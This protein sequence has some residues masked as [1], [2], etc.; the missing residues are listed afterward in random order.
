[1]KHIWSRSDFIQ[2][3]V[4]CP[5]CGRFWYKRLYSTGAVRVFTADGQARVG[6]AACKQL[7]SRQAET[8]GICFRSRE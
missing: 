1:M 2:V 8:L 3:F 6:H 4:V 7:A 5:V